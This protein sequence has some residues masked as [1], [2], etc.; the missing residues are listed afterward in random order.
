MTGALVYEY[1]ELLPLLA[2]HLEAND[3]EVLPHLL[4]ADIVVWMGHQVDTAPQLCSSMWQWLGSAYARGD[5]AIQNLIA[6]SAVEALPMP[7]QP[8]A[9]ALR[10]M[11]P[12]DLR[13]FDPWLG[14]PEL[15]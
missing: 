8:G 4:I 14:D 2:E 13:V 12:P 10:N 15:R 7:G 3:G 6:A 11:L 9:R 5:D 1:R